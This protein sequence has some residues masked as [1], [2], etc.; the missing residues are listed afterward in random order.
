MA[1]VMGLH[2]SEEVTDEVEESENRRQKEMGSE[3]V[4]PRWVVVVVMLWVRCCFCID[5]ENY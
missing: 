3:M 5:L 1:A 4:N 2:Y